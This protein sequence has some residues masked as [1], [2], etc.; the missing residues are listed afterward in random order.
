MGES[1]GSDLKPELPQ[2][3]DHQ[4]YFLI[5]NTLLLASVRRKQSNPS[6]NLL[7]IILVF[8]LA[9]FFYPSFQEA[10]CYNMPTYLVSVLGLELTMNLSNIC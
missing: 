6:E 4:I 3:R 10:P 1:V 5:K 2:F 8:L 9:A 7:F